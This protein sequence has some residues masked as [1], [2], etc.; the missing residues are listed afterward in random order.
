[1]KNETRTQMT[2]TDTND[3]PI[4]STA[5]KFGYLFVV[6]I[7]FIVGLAIG[8]TP[9]FKAKTTE[10]RSDISSTI[11]GV[12]GNLVPGKDDKVEKDVDF[13][14]FWTVWNTL[15]TQYVEQDISQKDMFYGAIKGM[16]GALDDPVTTYLTPD[17][18]KEYENGNKGEFQGIGAE[19]GYRDSNIIIVTP[20]E[21]SPAKA[22]GLFPGDII[23]KV[24]GE[25]ITGK[26][27][28][29]V[30]SIIRGEAGTEVKITIVRDGKEKDFTITRSKITVPSI[31]YKG[32]ENGIAVLDVDRF[33]EATLP[34][35]EEK[36]DEA[37]QQVAADDPKALI[38]DL[39]G[40]PGG[41][42]SAAVYAASEFLTPGDVVVQ[43]KD[44][45]DNVTDYTVQ[46]AGLLQDIPIIV[47]VN[48][49]SASA[50]E[51]FAGAIQ[52]NGRGK[53]LGE[54]TFGKGTAQDVI[55][56]PDGSS[57]HITIYKWLLPDGKWINPDN[58]I[59]PDIKVEL[60]EE[61]FENGED[62][63]LERAKKELQ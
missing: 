61:T 46:R 23:I 10:F 48:E 19:L 6:L 28:I 40:N 37:I 44:R 60:D 50:S 41:Y 31:T 30:V 8:L 20:L 7:A 58:P 47:L 59:K 9:T 36:W 49:G 17:E 38:I 26:S 3:T 5:E 18:T 52:K 54:N 21:G 42:F 27:I 4:S 62:P 32:E 34:E 43:Q 35:W 33:T 14:L 2:S 55:D 29:D 57:L 45:S 15:A 51:I 53:V 13:S 39:R 22:A 63:Q 24:D 56:Y 12:I 1:M 25:S 11:T 16:V